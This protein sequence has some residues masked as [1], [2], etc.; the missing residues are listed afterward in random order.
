MSQIV[1]YFITRSVTDGKM[2]G[3]IKSINKSA[4]NLFIYG[5]VQSS[6][7][8]KVDNLTYI[9]GKCL[10]EMRKDR[11]YMWKLVLKSE[12]L[13][14]VFAECGMG[15]KGSC[16]HIAAVA[17]A[18]VDFSHHGSL[19]EYQTS[20]QTL[21]Q[22][23]RP[24]QRHVDIVPVDKLGP[25]RRQLTSSITSYG[26]GVV[27]HPCPTSVRESN[28]SQAIERLRCYLLDLHQPYR[29]LNILAIFIENRT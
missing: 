2:A 10:T 23:N 27:F 1:A 28:S 14:I 12:E 19:P 26:S 29:L 13:D 22:W 17:Y 20:T 6:K 5:H 24:R 21:Q 4:E 3:G 8:V 7:F 9:R 16:K 11:I 18:L 25:R 15:P